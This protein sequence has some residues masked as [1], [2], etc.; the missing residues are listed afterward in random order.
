MLNIKNETD[1]A[2]SQQI[3]NSLKEEILSGKYPPGIRIRQED[4]AEQ[5][6]PIN[7]AQEAVQKGWGKISDAIDNF[8]QT[9][10]F[11]FSDLKFIT[12]LSN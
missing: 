1:L 9:G 5:F 11:S 2:L 7:M 10:K 3:A 12:Q 4:I 8:V 6:K